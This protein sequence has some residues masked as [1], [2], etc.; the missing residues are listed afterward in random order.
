[1]QAWF[2]YLVVLALVVVFLQALWADSSTFN[3]IYF[4]FL[5]VFALCAT[6]LF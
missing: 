6:T 1:M 5:A 3:L 4:H 2:R